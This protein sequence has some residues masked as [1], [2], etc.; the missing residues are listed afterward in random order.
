MNKSI[1][2]PLSEEDGIGFGLPLGDGSPS[3]FRAF[4]ARLLA[5]LLQPCR[6]LAPPRIFG[7]YALKRF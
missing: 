2:A 5:Q 6:L 4:A 7:D 3:H 1:P